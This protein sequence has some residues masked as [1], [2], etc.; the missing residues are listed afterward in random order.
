MEEVALCIVVVD[1]FSTTSVC[2]PGKVFQC[3][4]V[5][6]F[7]KTNDASGVISSAR[8]QNSLWRSRAAAGDRWSRKGLVNQHGEPFDL[9]SLCSSINCPPP[10]CVPLCGQ[11]FRTDFR[12]GGWLPGR[13]T[14]TCRSSSLLQGYTTVEYGYLH[15]WMLALD[16]FRHQNLM[17]EFYFSY[18]KVLLILTYICIRRILYQICWDQSEMQISVFHCTT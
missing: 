4:E 3:R 2:S 16:G 18:T 7:D 15:H 10:L 8:A 9:G 6:L 5:V 12:I 1:L 11:L 13:T 17:D 14:E